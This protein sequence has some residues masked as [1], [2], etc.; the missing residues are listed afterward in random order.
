MNL[1][2]IITSPGKDRRFIKNIEKLG[3]K[4]IF[5]KRGNAEHILTSIFS[6]NDGKKREK[7]QFMGQSLAWLKGYGDEPIRRLLNEGCNFEFLLLDPRSNL[8][9]RRVADE[10]PALQTEAEGFIKWIQK[11]FGDAYL[12]QIEL[13]V[14]DKTPTMG[15][16]IINE[17]QLFVSPYSMTGRTHKM[18]TFEF[19]KG[20]ELFPVYFQEFKNVWNSS[21]RRN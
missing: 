8:M 2:S 15:I 20:G 1:L 6:T 13:R 18:P 9:A 14:H 16:T 11:T 21:K 4:E 12:Y 7:L 17:N 10:N 19:S 5:Q 3:I